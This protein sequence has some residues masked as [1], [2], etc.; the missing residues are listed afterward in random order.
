M[1]VVRI[2]AACGV[3]IIAIGLRH[4]SAFGMPR[5]ALGDVGAGKAAAVPASPKPVAA[6]PPSSASVRQSG[7]LLESSHA[8]FSLF[9]KGA[10]WITYSVRGT[11]RDLETNANVSLQ[12]QGVVVVRGK[13]GV[14]ET[15]D[16]TDAAKGVLIED[17][18]AVLAA[19]SVADDS[20]LLYIVNQPTAKEL[21]RSGADR[22]TAL[23]AG[24]ADDVR[25]YPLTKSYVTSPDVREAKFEA[26]QGFV[27]SLTVGRA[28]MQGETSASVRLEVK[29]IV[30][31]GQCTPYAVRFVS[32]ELHGSLSTEAMISAQGNARKSL[33]LSKGLQQSQG[34]FPFMVGS[35]PLL[36]TLTSPFEMG[37]TSNGFAT[38][39][40]DGWLKTSGTFTFACSLRGCGATR[41]FDSSFQPSAAPSGMVA[42]PVKVLAWLQGSVEL[43]LGSNDTFAAQ[44]GVRAGPTL[45]LRSYSGNACGD[46]DGDGK[47]ETISGSSIETSTQAEFKTSLS[48]LGAE[49]MTTSYRF[50]EV[51]EGFWHSDAANAPW[52]PVLTTKSTKGQQVTL[53]AG[54]RS[55][56]P[57]SDPVTFQV[58]WDDGTV[59]ERT[60][61]PGL[62]ELIHS[63]KK[64]GNHPVRVVLQ[65]D[66]QGRRFDTV[67]S[68]IVRLPAS[69]AAESG[70]SLDLP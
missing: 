6:P 56:W 3:A 60:L 16:L 1:S 23:A 36:V 45:D 64:P 57:Y 59:T 70:R 43:A 22:S 12:G 33:T 48:M 19:G 46:A 69:E 41:S 13:S 25:D 61:P 38:V 2:V 52:T 14:K 17:M 8:A 54:T 67:A 7:P 63:F 58:T 20:E 31:D 15:P 47:P 26:G 55:C 39:A 51:H 10:G 65:R 21:G 24:C 44:V 50:A 62:H 53:V 32:S 30:L 42:E 29:R 49:P 34:V 5:A 35:V 28:S 66:A 68:S 18:E 9:R 11:F 37:L 27:G 4:D 40:V